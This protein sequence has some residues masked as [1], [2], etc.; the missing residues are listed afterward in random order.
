MA[1]LRLFRRHQ[2]NCSKSRLLQSRA[3]QPATRAER[4]ADCQCGIA[5]EGT[6]RRRGYVTNKATK[7]TDW[8]KAEALAERWE[9]W[10]DFV[11]PPSVQPVEV[12]IEY[13]VD[14]FLASTGPQGRNVDPSTLRTFEILL[15]RRLFEYAK[16]RGFRALG[17]LDDLDVVTK[18]VESWQ[19]LNPHRNRIA[20]GPAK[21]VPLSAS[22]KRAELERLRAF[23]R[24]CADRQ[25][26]RSNHATKIRFKSKIEKKFGMEPAEEKLVFESIQFVEDGR[27]RTGQYNARELSAFCL[28]MR[29]AGL[30]IGDATT[31]N[32]GQLVARQSGK[33]WALRVFQQK[34]EDWVYIPIPDFVETELRKL[35]FKGKKDGCNYWF[36]TCEGALDTATTNWRERVSRLL[37]AAQKTKPFAHKA[38]THSFRHTFSIRHLNAGTDIKFVSRWL[39]HASVLTTEKH[40]AHAIRGTMIASEE[41]YDQS[42]ARQANHGQLLEAMPFE[43]KVH[44]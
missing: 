8:S 11:P 37:A 24:Y 35:K 25:W 18:F 7:E 16:H 26:I 27:G 31:L 36:W 43:E 9:E 6:L 12:S 2:K 21:P 38:T 14:S 44:Q 34:T 17:Q 20:V 3:Y 33:G 15:K 30:R 42:I 32:D 40:Y 19:N 10:G 1:T 13:A 39:G 22:T 5:V 41:A 23:F 28:V 29:Y 4:A